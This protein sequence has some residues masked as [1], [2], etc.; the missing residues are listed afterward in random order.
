[1]S[2]LRRKDVKTL[3]EIATLAERGPLIAKLAGSVSARQERKSARGNRFA[4]VQLSDPTGLYEVTCFSEVLEA[5]REL[6][7]PG[8]NVVLVVKAEL[9][10][11]SLKL[12]AQSVTAIDTVAA[13]A[14]ARP[15]R[16]HL[17]RAEAVSS[18]ASL[19][20]RAEG[21]NLAQVTLCVTDPEGREV[22][23][24]LPDAYPI[25]PQIKGAIKAV[26]GV[27]AVEDL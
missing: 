15:I 16:I 21:R 9:E 13:Q 23:I 17:S 5:S 4:F 19:L 27:V 10:G 18:L 12:L 1:M 6:L 22:D 3:A 7:E 24:D 11:E 20:A 8:R 14:G 2:A 25:T 26:Q